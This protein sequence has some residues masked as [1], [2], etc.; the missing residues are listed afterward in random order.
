MKG[1]SKFKGP[2]QGRQAMGKGA[3]A[4]QYTFDSNVTKM[5]ILFA[6]HLVQTRSGDDWEH[7]PHGVRNQFVE[8]LP[9]KA[10]KSLWD[11]SCA[12]TEAA[13]DEIYE[14]ISEATSAGETNEIAWT[15]DMAVQITEMPTWDE[16]RRERWKDDYVAM[17]TWL[18]GSVVKA[19]ADVS[20]GVEA[21]QK[22]LGMPLS[23]KM[24]DELEA[25]LKKAFN[26]LPG[27]ELE[28]QDASRVA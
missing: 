8:E 14:L 22:Q 25:L 27:V 12:D 10:L 15:L 7:V 9:H 3:K 16:L 11:A 17:H 13:R 18:I 4:M 28:R 19:P 20:A 2:P 1:L 21:V 6:L 24:R 23:T 26:G 5:K